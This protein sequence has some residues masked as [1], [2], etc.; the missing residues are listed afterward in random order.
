MAIGRN[1]AAVG[2]LEG[3]VGNSYQ[4]SVQRPLV[5]HGWKQDPGSERGAMQRNGGRNERRGVKA[6]GAAVTKEKELQA[7]C[8]TQ[9]PAERSGARALQLHRC[10]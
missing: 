9:G 7:V 1:A 2:L 8:Q 5:P 6:T 4:S 10:L 3:N